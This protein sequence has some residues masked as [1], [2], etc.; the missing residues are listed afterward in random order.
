MQFTLNHVQLFQTHRKIVHRVCIAGL[1]FLELLMDGDSLARV[2]LQYPTHSQSLHT[3]RRYSLVFSSFFDKFKYSGRE[4]SSRCD[5]A[6]TFLSLSIIWALV[7]GLIGTGCRVG[8]F[9][10]TSF[11]NSFMRLSRPA[12]DTT[13]WLTASRCP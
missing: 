4:L 3:K 7:F 13:F 9:L 2:S 6:L 5:I 8:I 10:I 12:F 1:S 11:L